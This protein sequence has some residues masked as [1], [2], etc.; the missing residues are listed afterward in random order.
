MCLVRCSSQIFQC[1]LGM[2]APRLILN[3][4]ETNGSRTSGQTTLDP[5]LCLSRTNGLSED[6]VTLHAHATMHVEDALIVRSNDR[7]LTNFPIDE[8]RTTT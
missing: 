3:G 7:V 6:S 4:V 8:V 5:S 2:L 1:E